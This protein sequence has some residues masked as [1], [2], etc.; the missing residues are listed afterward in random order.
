MSAFVV[1]MDSSTAKIFHIKGDSVSTSK[2]IRHEVDHHRHNKNDMK[3]KDSP[4]FFTEV[5]DHLKTMKDSVLLVG[6]GVTRNHFITYLEG[7]HDKAL[8]HRIVATEP[9]DHP[10]DAQIVAYARK[11]FPKAQTA[12]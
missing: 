10:T 2:A 4:E 12:T 8:A 11:Y 5:A 7:H 3:Q 6:P 9:L 1:W